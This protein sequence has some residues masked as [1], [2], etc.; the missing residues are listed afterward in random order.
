MLVNQ[1]HRIL[2][3]EDNQTDVQLI[4]EALAA[5]GIEHDLIV[6]EDGDKAMKHLSDSAAAKP[7]LI[8]LDL[9]MPTHDGLEVLVKYRMNVTFTDVPMVVL[10]S[11]NSPGD[12]QR[13]KNIGVS[14]FIQKPMALPEFIALGKRFKEILQTPYIYT[15]P[16]E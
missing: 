4:Q 9:Q 2:V 5:H 10:T 3:I 11:S 13:A 14:A 12:R 1:R 15:G 8:I 6:L 7:D 16:R